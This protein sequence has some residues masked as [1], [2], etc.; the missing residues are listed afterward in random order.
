LAI[1]ITKE[2]SLPNRIIKAVCKNCL[3]EFNSDILDWELHFVTKDSS[4]N[5]V[6]DC[7][8]AGC[9]NRIQISGDAACFREYHKLK[10]GF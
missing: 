10:H 4:P 6:I 7:P 9:D 1:E 8:K 5:Y 2:G 3:T